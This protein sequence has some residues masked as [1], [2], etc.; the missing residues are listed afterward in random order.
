M[1]D[2]TSSAIE[3]LK[4]L[5]VS[6]KMPFTIRFNNHDKTFL[7]KVMGKHFQRTDLSKALTEAIKFMS[8]AEG[9]ATKKQWETTSKELRINSEYNKQKTI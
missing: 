6:S 9:Y 1:K 8:I 3:T 5:C 2:I 7:V 4:I